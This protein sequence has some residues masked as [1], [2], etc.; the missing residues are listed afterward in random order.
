VQKTAISVSE[1][2]I[3]LQ[4]AERR[5]RNDLSGSNSEAETSPHLSVQ[6]SVSRHR[7]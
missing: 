4:L 7:L 6:A 3:V 1:P 2:V 5:F